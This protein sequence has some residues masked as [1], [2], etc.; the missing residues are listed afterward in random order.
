MD[1]KVSASAQWLREQRSKRGSNRRDVLC[2]DST[3]GRR[4]VI[5]VL[6]TVRPKCFWLAGFVN[7]LNT[8]ATLAGSW[9]GVG[10]FDTYP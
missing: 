1:V 3:K 9:F 8:G 2:A 6:T 5:G 4:A 10:V 7:H